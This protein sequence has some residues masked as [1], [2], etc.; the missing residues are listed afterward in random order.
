MT[1]VWR[2][3]TA[4][5]PR[6]AFDGEGARRFPGT[7]HPRGVA[8]VYASGSLSLAALELLVHAEPRDLRRP[9]YATHADLPDEL[10]ET[11][12]ESDLPADWQ[13]RGREDFRR[14]LGS[15]WAASGR[16]L[17]LVVPSRIIPSEWNALLNPGHPAFGRLELGRPARFLLGASGP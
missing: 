5:G 10:V 11:L 6:G 13:A 4:A 8:V 12:T 14:Q 1:R 7:W 3:S 9:L 15:E 17:A 16:S 2:L